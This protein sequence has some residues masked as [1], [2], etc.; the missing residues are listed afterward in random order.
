MCIIIYSKIHICNKIKNLQ[1][2]KNEKESKTNRT[3]RKEYEKEI[4]NR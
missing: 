2:K 4:N 1:R 3:N